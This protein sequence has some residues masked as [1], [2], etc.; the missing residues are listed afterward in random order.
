MDP[1]L[2]TAVSTAP[3]A[4]RADLQVQ[5]VGMRGSDLGEGRLPFD[6]L[7]HGGQVEP[8]VAQGT[9]EFDTSDGVDTEAAVTGGTAVE[10]RDDP[11]VG[12]E[13][14]GLDRGPG[15]PREFPDRV[16]RL[17]IHG[18]HSGASPWG[19][20]KAAGA[21]D[22]ANGARTSGPLGAS[23][24][25]DAPRVGAAHGEGEAVRQVLEDADVRLLGALL[26]RA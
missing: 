13:P 4:Q 19:R 8:E 7:P 11:L 22:V 1:R 12:I 14:N 26:P 20:G 18:P 15:Q 3:Q 10:G 6:D 24:A 5:R 21:A 17:P 25:R 9:N 23:D 2:A 16:E